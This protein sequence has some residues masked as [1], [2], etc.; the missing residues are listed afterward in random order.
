MCYANS[1]ALTL[2]LSIFC[3]G[4]ELLNSCVATREK[5]DILAN[6]AVHFFHLSNSPFVK[7][8]CVSEPAE[9]FSAS[10]WLLG[11][12]GTVWNFEMVGVNIFFG[13]WRKHWCVSL[14]STEY[15]RSFHV[16][17]LP[18]PCFS[19]S[20]WKLCIHGM[21][22]G[23]IYGGFGMTNIP[24]P[25]LTEAITTSNPL[26]LKMSYGIASSDNLQTAAARN[27]GVFV[28]A[29]STQYNSCTLPRTMPL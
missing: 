10:F 18:L 7:K 20:N 8:R 26:D 13:A 4:T 15:N 24:G 2:T 22:S 27:S 14:G 9:S 12:R 21:C 17:V 23:A 29:S 6:F 25:P 28:R 1:G 5:M 11:S 19:R 16:L 3:R